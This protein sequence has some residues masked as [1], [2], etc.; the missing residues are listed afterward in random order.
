MR[1]PDG[2]KEIIEDVDTVFTSVL[3]VKLPVTAIRDWLRGLPARRMSVKE[4]N[5]N[6]QGLINVLKQSGWRVE[7]K[8]YV[9]GEILMPHAIYL[10]RA[11]NAALDIR[12]IIRRWL[13]DVE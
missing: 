8:K 12:L 10:S 1:Y 7:M 9:G 5:W 4:I 6:D 13:I 2:H 3:A 11:D